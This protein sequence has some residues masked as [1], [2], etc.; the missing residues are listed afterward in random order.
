MRKTIFRGKT[1]FGEWIYWN[2]YG[3]MVDENG[4]PKV[5]NIDMIRIIYVD[6]ARRFI[7]PETVGQYTGLPDKNRKKIFEG[8]ILCYEDMT[9]RKFYGVV[10][11]GKWNCSCCHGVYGYATDGEH[12]DIQDGIISYIAGNIH[13]NPEL[14]TQD[15]L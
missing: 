8:D 4:N 11:Y 14:L 3:S 9:E 6:T 12:V 10:R 1:K 15:S 13:D 2:E 5:Y 7:I